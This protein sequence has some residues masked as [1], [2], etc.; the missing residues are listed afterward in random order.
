MI[1]T[2]THNASLF[3]TPQRL[4]WDMIT[5]AKKTDSISRVRKERLEVQGYRGY[6]AVELN[7]IKYG[8]RFPYQV[9]TGLIVI[10]LATMNAYI[11]AFVGVFAFFCALGPYHPFDY[12]YNYVVRQAFHK[13]AM[14]RRSSQSRFMCA[15]A[16]T[17]LAAIVILFLTGFNVAA[18][19]VGGSLLIVAILA[20]TTDICIPSMIYNL[21]FER[22]TSK[23]STAN[24]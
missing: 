4:T 1:K 9:S 16:T 14:P 13:P 23:Q 6:T 15:M 5:P 20:S 24:L 7:E 11:I 3:V 17:W 8:V 10:G 2:Y 12:L 18:L 21:L 22:K 19:A